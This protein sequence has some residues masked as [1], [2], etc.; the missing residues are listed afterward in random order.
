MMYSPPVEVDPSQAIREEPPAS[1]SATDAGMSRGAVP[2]GVAED[3][4]ADLGEEEGAAGARRH[5]GTVTA[6][7]RPDCVGLTGADVL[8][9]LVAHPHPRHHFT[10]SPPT[11]RPF[12]H[13]RSAFLPVSQ[14]QLSPP[15]AIGRAE[16]PIAR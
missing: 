11:E 13:G 10:P 5:F 15:L 7:A 9:I 8:S 16:R 1:A 12:K 3:G 2:R 4:Q 6:G 14:A